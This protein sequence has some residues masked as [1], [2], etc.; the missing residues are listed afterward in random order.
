MPVAGCEASSTSDP[1]LLGPRMIVQVA[2]D[3]AAVLR[4]VAQRV[5][6]AVRADESLAALDK[7]EQRALAG[8]AREWQLAD[9][10]SRT[11]R[12]RSS[13]DVESRVNRCEIFGRG[14]IVTDRSRCARS[15][16]RSPSRAVRNR[17]RRLSANPS[18]ARMK[19]QHSVARTPGN[20][21]SADRQRADGLRWQPRTSIGSLNGH[22]QP[23]ETG[24]R[25]FFDASRL[26]FDLRDLRVTFVPQGFGIRNVAL[27]IALPLRP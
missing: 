1:C 10:S 14:D 15:T 25:Y 18:R 16:S 13:R 7:R 2:A 23:N 3:Q 22:E 19:H 9:W 24:T 11:S 27:I 12:H 5:G 4:P 8:R 6:R 26:S 17:T 21:Q 20:R